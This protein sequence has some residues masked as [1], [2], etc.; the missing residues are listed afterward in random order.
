[1]H[2]SMCL[3]CRLSLV[4]WAV[5]SRALRVTLWPRSSRVAAAAAPTPLVVRSVLVCC[6]SRF[7]R[8]GDP[9]YFV[10]VASWARGCGA[11]RGRRRREELSD[12]KKEVG[13]GEG[14][15][16]LSSA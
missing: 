10:G 2:F 1:M 4:V 8:A 12:P 11:G 3:S 16:C 14:L 5:R 9:L 7:A 6:V 13:G 15:L